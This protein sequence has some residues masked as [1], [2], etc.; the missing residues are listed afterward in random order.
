[1]TM[2]VVRTLLTVACGASLL[3]SACAQDNRATHCAVI[4]DV[5]M[6]DIA[7]TL[8]E[9]AVS[10]DLQKLNEGEFARNYGDEAG[11]VV[12]WLSLDA[13]KGSARVSILEGSGSISTS[14]LADDFEAFARQHF[15]EKFQ[16]VEC[17]A[18]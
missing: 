1:M 12:I 8:D 5:D 9:F 18:A 4:T 7:S 14:K 17:S 10:S 15:A 13:S 3:T 11:R 2:P 6:A 16:T